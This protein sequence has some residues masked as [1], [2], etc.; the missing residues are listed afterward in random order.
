MDS[1]E[2]LGLSLIQRSVKDDVELE[3]KMNHTNSTSEAESK[4]KSRTLKLAR[5]FRNLRHSNHM[6]KDFVHIVEFKPNMDVMDSA[7]GK[8]HA[9]PHIKRGGRRTEKACGETH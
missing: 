7:K 3:L 8:M 2:E 6:V 5:R 9:D 4:V 1:L